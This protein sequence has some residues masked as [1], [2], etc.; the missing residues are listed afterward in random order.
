[1]DTGATVTINGDIQQF[2]NLKPC[3]IKVYCANGEVMVAKECGTLTLQ[4]GDTV[5]EIPDCLYIP[6]VVTLISASQLTNQLKLKILLDDKYVSIYKSR[7][8]IIDDKPIMKTKKRKRDKLWKVPLLQ[9]PGENPKR[10]PKKRHKVLSAVVQRRKEHA[11]YLFELL[12]D[13][14]PSVLHA[15]YGHCRMN[16]LQ[17]K[18]PHL[19]NKHHWDICSACAAH[20]N[21]KSYKKS[22][23]TDDDGKVLHLCYEKGCY[24]CKSHGPDNSGIDHEKNLESHEDSPTQNAT[25]NEFAF[26]AI[27]YS[28]EEEGKKRFGRY[29]S[30]DTKSCSTKSIR[31]YKYL[32]IVV[33]HDT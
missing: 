13:V 2:K 5:L 11:R 22:Y 19:M 8:D 1:M 24:S 12:K 31:G 14:K 33:D 30:S 29:F 23:K 9:G 7:Q 26:G 25:Q 28:I 16:R 15:R 17:K 27:D 6:N 32:F 10:K 4:D 3:D 20:E 21:R 18:F